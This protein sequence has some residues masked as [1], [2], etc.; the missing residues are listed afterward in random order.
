M[1][2]PDLMTIARHVATL[3]ARLPA[4]NSKAAAFKVAEEDTQALVSRIVEHSVHA[5]LLTIRAS[6]P[7]RRKGEP[8]RALLEA[9]KDLET[10]TPE[11]APEEFAEASSHDLLM[12]SAR[13]LAVAQVDIRQIAQPLLPENFKVRLTFGSH[14]GQTVADLWAYQPGYLVWLTE[15]DDPAFQIQHPE[16]FDAAFRALGQEP[17]Q[18]VKDLLAPGAEPPKQDGAYLRRKDVPPGLHTYAQWRE[19][20]LLV[21]ADQ[22]NKPAATWLNEGRKVHYFSQDQTCP[23]QDNAYLE[24]LDERPTDLLSKQQWR[25]RE[26]GIA[27]DA[28]P[29]GAWV[30]YQAR[31]PHIPLYSEDQ[32]TSIEV[33]RAVVEKRRRTR[34]RKAV[35]H[36]LEQGKIPSTD[37]MDEETGVPT[38]E[39]KI[40]LTRG[41]SLVIT[42]DENP[43]AEAAEAAGVSLDELVDLVVPFFRAEGIRALIQHQEDHAGPVPGG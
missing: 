30:P 22:I 14:A 9:L 29:E 38:G 21:S 18:V 5:S 2:L 31:A 43:L 13:L 3:A 36:A 26:R 19:K 1:Q 15:Q 11:V 41:T 8:A 32:T 40:W 34:L 28:Q 23:A 42:P 4:P 16:I 25:L 17:P 10:D 35:S 39:Y 7:D 33:D 24:H 6:G 20:R 12:E 37:V 27:K